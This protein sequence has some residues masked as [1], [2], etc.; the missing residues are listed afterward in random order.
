MPYVSGPSF[1]WA[2]P[3]FYQLEKFSFP[4][5]HHALGRP[6]VQHHV[7]IRP[8]PMECH[9]WAHAHGEAHTNTDIDITRICGNAVSHSWLGEALV[10]LTTVYSFLRIHRETCWGWSL[11]IHR[12][13]HV[14]CLHGTCLVCM[15]ET[16]RAFSR[17][18]SSFWLWQDGK[19]GWSHLCQREGFLYL[20]L[21][22]KFFR[23]HHTMSVQT[24]CLSWKSHSSIHNFLPPQTPGDKLSILSI[25]YRNRPKTCMRGYTHIHLAIPPSHLEL[26]EEEKG[27]YRRCE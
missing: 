8:C 21:A 2:S 20:R 25:P 19:V 24:H 11:E 26:W 27:G 1:A 23:W 13:H 3:R 16:A 15:C 14:I 22:W 12:S 9:C 5:R 4:W 18:T 6:P 7:V 10:W 17:P